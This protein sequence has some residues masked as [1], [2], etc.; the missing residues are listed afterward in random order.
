MVITYR[1]T[2][3]WEPFMPYPCDFPWTLYSI[4]NYIV[5]Y[6]W[7]IFAAMSVVIPAIGVDT[8]F[9]G[10]THHLCAFFKIA[11][12]RMATYRCSTLKQTEANLKEIFKIYQDSL[13]MCVRLNQCFEPLIFVQFFVSS[14]QLCVV[15][16][17]F[18]LNFNQPQGIYYGSY[19]VSTVIQTFCY[20]YCGEYLK[21][22]SLNFVWAIYDSPWYNETRSSIGI[23]RSMLISM[24][25][26]QNACRITGYFFEANM[27]A[28]SAIVR[29][30][31]SY[32]TMLRSF[33]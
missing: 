9:C 22:E 10:F 3:K 5:C 29:T 28:F 24:M 19:M 2:G 6:L 31:M 16:Y 13:D 1:Q 25:R 12:N 14:L 20:C 30:A 4:P 11:Q 23:T 15:G 7:S 18:S 21:T 33:S 32:I 17:L 27:Q 8:L 26:A